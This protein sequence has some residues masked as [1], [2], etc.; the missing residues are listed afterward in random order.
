MLR[1]ESNMKKKFL[2][3]SGPNLNLLGSRKASIYDYGSLKDI[4]T[5]LKNMQK[6]LN[7]EG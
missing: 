2:V 3:V 4:H 7:V 1:G 5:V 6:K